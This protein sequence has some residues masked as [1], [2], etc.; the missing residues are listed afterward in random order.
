MKQF[1]LFI[2]LCLFLNNPVLAKSVNKKNTYWHDLSVDKASSYQ[3][4]NEL[5]RAGTESQKFVLKHGSCGT[6][7][8]YSDCV[9]DSQRTERIVDYSQ[10][11]NKT[12]YYAYSIYI[13]EDWIKLRRSEISLGQVKPFSNNGGN[14]KPLWIIKNRGGMLFVSIAYA[15]RD[16]VLA[17]E[18]T[19]KGKWNDIVIKA[20]YSWKQKEKHSYFKVWL[21]GK[22]MC[23]LKKPIFTKEL[24]KQHME[25]NSL[26][27]VRLN[28]S[29]GIYHNNV[30]QWLDY[31]KTKSPENIKPYVEKESVFAPV[32]S[33]AS[34]PFEHDWG[35]ELPTRV[36]YYDEMKIGNTLESV[37]INQNKPVD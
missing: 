18:L 34:S 23:D 8:K 25:L 31:H 19:I 20:D 10:Q 30:S 17:N 1:I 5:V 21:N 35:V 32:K 16:C 33:I 3:I 14:S 7:K 6:D 28:Y 37:Q 11:L 29:Y 15:N 12:Y 2:G 9:N 27:S 22:L 24:L 26:N 36:V 13:P 4:T